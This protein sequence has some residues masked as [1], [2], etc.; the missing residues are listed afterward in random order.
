MKVK[1]TYFKPNGKLYTGGEYDTEMEHMFQIFQE[2]ANMVELGNLPGLVP[3]TPCN[4]I[5][6]V[7]VPD[8]PHNHPHLINTEAAVV[9]YAL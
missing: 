6:H 8:H 1:L 5:V 2:V 9:L 7:S 3:R 4:F